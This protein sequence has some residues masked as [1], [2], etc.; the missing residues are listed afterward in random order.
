VTELVSMREAHASVC[1]ADDSPSVF[2]TRLLL[3]MMTA[4]RSS[5]GAGRAC[6][7]HSRDAVTAST[8]RLSMAGCH[9]CLLTA[10]LRSGQLKVVNAAA[11]LLDGGPSLFICPLHLLVVFS[12]SLRLWQSRFIFCCSSVP[13]GCTRPRPLLLAC[14]SCWSASSCLNVGCLVRAAVQR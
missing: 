13:V 6:A 10:A 1:C 4:R 5:R 12:T 3:P 14:C 2:V 11:G 8:C 7:G 9:R